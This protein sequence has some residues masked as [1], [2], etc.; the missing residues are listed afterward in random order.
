M[1]AGRFE[2][3]DGHRVFVPTDAPTGPEPGEQPR[4]DQQ[5]RSG[6]LLDS[7]TALLHLPDVWVQADE[8]RCAVVIAMPSH[9]ARSLAP[10]AT[11]PL[12][13][14]LAAQLVEAAE[15][16][17]AAHRDELTEEAL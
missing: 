4:A 5:V 3:V 11:D 15:L 14:L 13:V 9:V 2:N 8:A 10:Y 12:Q 6:A 16:D 17:A 1:T 7:L